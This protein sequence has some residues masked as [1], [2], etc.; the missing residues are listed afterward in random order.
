MTDHPMPP[1]AP[2]LPVASPFPDVAPARPA[3]GNALAIGLLLA[4]L[5]FGIP[6]LTYCVLTSG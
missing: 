5:L 4:I 2:R 3:T 1:D 6:L